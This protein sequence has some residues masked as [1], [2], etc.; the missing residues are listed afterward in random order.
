MF[1]YF[2]KIKHITLLYVYTW[3][4]Q[5]SFVNTQ[6]L[7]NCLYTL[8][9]KALCGHILCIQFYIYIVYLSLFVD[10]D[11]VYSVY[12]YCVPKDPLWTHRTS[13]VV[14]VCVCGGVGGWYTQGSE[15][16]IYYVHSCVYTLRTPSFFVYTYYIHSCYISAVS[17]GG[18]L[19]SSISLLNHRT[20][21]V[22]SVPINQVT[23]I[24]QINPFKN[25][26]PPIKSIIF[27]KC[28]NAHC[29]NQTAQVS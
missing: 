21:I 14:C 2:Y 3:C 16:D 24:Y 4:T 23:P 28:P 18:C 17:L 10:T 13:K 19:A 6:H 8:F 9:H 29:T 15:V 26:D 7:Y 12:M 22:K 1:Q 11:Y 27:I 20:P 5:S 25:P